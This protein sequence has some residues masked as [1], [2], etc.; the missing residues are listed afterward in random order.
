MF[1]N[2]AGDAWTAQNLGKLLA[3]RIDGVLDQN[4]Y[5]CREEARRQGQENRIRVLP[6][7]VDRVR[8][9]VVFSRASPKGARLL[10]EFN[11]LEITPELDENIMILKFLEGLK[12]E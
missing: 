12:Q 9:Y 3:G 10:R 6:L 7:P 8:S 4:E 2:V 5:S 1:E 11:A